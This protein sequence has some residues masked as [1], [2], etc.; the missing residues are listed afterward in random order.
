[1][2]AFFDTNVLVYL[3]DEDAPANKARAQKLL[4]EE[5][6]RGQAVLSTQVLEEFYVS[7]TRKLAEP[8]ESEMAERAVR[9]LAAL[10]LIQIDAQMILAAI[11]RS[12]DLQLSFWDALIIEA[13]I[14]SGADRLF[15]E[16]LRHGQQIESVRIENPFLI[17][18]VGEP[19]PAGVGE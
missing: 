11:R 7:V 8:L 1:M 16:D 10:P 14:T 18:T 6:S 5:V 19:G 4:E 17:G 15:T 13:A 3:F 2:R 9:D 12:R